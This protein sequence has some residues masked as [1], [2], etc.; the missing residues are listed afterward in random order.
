MDS[1]NPSI[2]EILEASRLNKNKDI[3]QLLDEIGSGNSSVLSGHY[4]QEEGCNDFSTQSTDSYTVNEA[5]ECHHFSDCQPFR[6]FVEPLPLVVPP[7]PVSS[8]SLGQPADGNVWVGQSA[9]DSLR[10]LAVEC[11][12]ASEAFSLGQSSQEIRELN[13]EIKKQEEKKRKRRE[14]NKQ[15]SREF[16]RKQKVREQLLTRGKAEKEQLLLERHKRMEKTTK[17]LIKIA[18]SSGACEKGRA[19]I[20]MVANLINKENMPYAKG[21]SNS[22]PVSHTITC[23]KTQGTS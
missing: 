4:W 12:Q 1:H 14:R 9:T 13:D 7:I 22:T 6:S 2:Q 21:A 20:N 15:C 17:I 16:R 18:N 10:G 11:I 5:E 23:T 19:I 8:C 3:L